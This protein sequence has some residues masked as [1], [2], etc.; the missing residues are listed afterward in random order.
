MRHFTQLSI[1]E[2]EKA[3]VY[4][5]KGMKPAEIARELGREKSTII[6]EIK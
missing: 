2:K 4:L 3:R 5:G 6:R 1:E